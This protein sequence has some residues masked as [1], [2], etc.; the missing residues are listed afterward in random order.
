M[1]KEL[2]SRV[3]RGLRIGERVSSSTI[4]RRADEDRCSRCGHRRLSSRGC[5]SGFH[6]DGATT[7]LERYGRMLE[8]RSEKVVFP[9]FEGKLLDRGFINNSLDTTIETVSELPRVKPKKNLYSVTMPACSGK[10][11]L[12]GKY[13]FLDIDGCLGQ[14]GANALSHALA[15][16]RHGASDETKARA[17]VWL[18]CVRDCFQ[19]FTF[20]KPTLVLVHDDLTGYMTGATKVGACSLPLEVKKRHD[21]SGKEGRTQLI[22]INHDVFERQNDDAVQF[23]TYSE[24]EAYVVKRAR[25]FGV[26]MGG[27]EGCR[28]IGQGRASELSGIE[29]VRAWEAG[30]VSKEYVEERMLDDREYETYGFGYNLNAWLSAMAG[31]FYQGEEL[32]DR[33]GDLLERFQE[34]AELTGHV[35][36]QKLMRLKISDDDKIKRVTWWLSTG[37]YCQRSDIMYT[38]IS[39][40]GQN[41]PRVFMS[42]AHVLRRSR[43]I[44]DA[45]VEDGDRLDLLSLCRLYGFSGDLDLYQ[46]M[47]LEAQDENDRVVR[48]CKKASVRY[49]NEA[50]SEIAQEYTSV[51][52]ST[53]KYRIS[54][55][56]AE[57]EGWTTGDVIALFEVLRKAGEHGWFGRGRNV[58]SAVNKLVME[59]RRKMDRHGWD[60]A[61]KH[62]LDSPVT[63]YPGVGDVVL[64]RGLDYIMH[65]GREKVH[66]LERSELEEI[67]LWGLGDPEVGTPIWAVKCAVT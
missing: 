21:Y 46:E 47:S 58:R 24:V 39:G 12:S 20:D 61:V 26:S 60:T 33:A 53:P 50:L 15:M 18:E 40:I 2:S 25:R 56:L 42:L 1:D 29:L 19:G 3:V 51:Q 62:M 13:G 41:G 55:M 65:S 54:S 66:V 30:Q 4:V 49:L 36:A 23:E 32:N 59:E 34:R 7:R 14:S 8:G 28:A 52:Q 17:K 27:D 9:K 37:R 64:E 43:F 11:T 6:N 5:D 10:T 22:E 63:S 35:D 48:H 57:M 67:L 45:S 38:L 16:H 31:G 44:F